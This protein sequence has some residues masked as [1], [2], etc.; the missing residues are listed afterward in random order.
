MASIAGHALSS[1]FLDALAVD[2]ERLTRINKALELIPTEQRAQA[3]WRPIDLLVISPSER[4]DEIAVR[5]TDSLPLS[6]KKLM[7]VLG[8]SEHPTRQQGGAFASY[9]LFEAAYT[10]ELM[11]LG[12]RDALAKAAEVCRFFAWTPG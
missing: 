2:I 6:V 9:L 12:R 10:Q 4:L 5:H 11:A 8:S 3:Q 1:I 7:R